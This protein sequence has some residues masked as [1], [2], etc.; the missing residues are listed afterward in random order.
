MAQFVGTFKEFN[1]YIGP[2]C[3]S[4]VNY[5]T[6]KERK[7]HN[8]IC[9]HCGKKSELES[10]HKKG[11]ERKDIVKSLF[12]KLNENKTINLEKFKRDFIDIHKPISKHFFFL[13]N[14]CH[15]KYD[16]KPKKTTGSTKIPTK[17]RK[18][19][20]Y[21]KNT[22]SDDI[23]LKC[24]YEYLS[25]P[26][27]SFRKIEES[28]LDIN[29]PI[30]GGGFVSKGI[31]NDLGV[32]YKQRGILSKHTIVQEISNT[33]NQEYKKTLLKIQTLKLI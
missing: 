29:S 7:K 21:D 33:N 28:I 25:N 22:Y 15:G 4:K 13:C 6:R 14:S 11:F 9:E 18:T 2:Y 19:H 5:I 23:K 20:S 30:R 27:T 26:N 1:E 3:R 32:D 8:E 12:K 24:A 17:I 31:I 16:A 10:A